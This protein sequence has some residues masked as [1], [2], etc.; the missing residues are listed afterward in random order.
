MNLQQRDKKFLARDNDP[1]NIEVVHSESSFIINAKGKK[2]IDFTSGWCVGNL[3]WNNKEITKSI[4]NFKGPTYVYPGLLYAP[5]VE[6]AELLAKITPGR[7]T[8]CFRAT[9]GT[10]AVDIA[11]RIAN[12]YT[13]KHKF[14]S[15]EGS[16][17][18]DSIG[19]MSVG[20][21]TFREHQKG[22]LFKSL[23]VKPPLNDK[24]ADQI[25]EYLKGKDVAAVIMEP[26]ICNL[27]VVIPEKSFMT[28]LQKLCKQHNCLL[29]ID[30]VATGFGRTGKLFG[31]ELFN[32]KPDIMVMAKAITGGYAPL[33]AV[34]T[35][36]QISASMKFD[37]SYYSTYG[38]HPLAVAAAIA[39]IKF[40]QK[41]QDE[42]LDHT[43]EISEYFQERL[44]VMKFK[45]E[46]DIRIKGLAIGFEFKK[47]GYANKIV[48]C[49]QKKG[50]L[51]SSH[52]ETEFTM[53]PPLNITKKTAE[54]GLDI[55]EACL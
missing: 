32:L 36:K 50:L 12:A 40:I 18:G 26:I 52:S 24:A 9:G 38:W 8:T 37:S 53:F 39:N 10:E 31:A 41:H 46:R 23:K 7:L 21:S 29:I 22:L 33:G 43:L 11:L 27:A 25:E 28:R 35:T 2:F 48:D 34:I 55:F 6:L 49:A 44:S 45:S 13:E 4:K 14:I 5:W 15:I 47:K 20:A 17:H 54:Q 51:I 19:A 30:E 1:S 16:Y 42:L 3:G